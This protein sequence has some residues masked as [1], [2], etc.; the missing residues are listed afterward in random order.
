MT[1]R[2]VEEEKNIKMKYRKSFF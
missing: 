2:T 1:L